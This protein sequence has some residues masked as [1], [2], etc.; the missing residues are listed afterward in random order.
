MEYHIVSTT[1]KAFGLAV[2]IPVEHDDIPLFVGTCHHVRSH[3]HPPQA[4]AFQVVA[5]VVVESGLVARITY[6][7]AIV[8][9]YEELRNTIAVHVAQRNVVDDVLRCGIFTIAVYHFCNGKLLVALV[10]T[11]H[12]GTLRLFNALHYSRHLILCGSIATSVVV[13]RGLQV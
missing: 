4:F 6:V 10:P 1:K 11:C 13:V 9:L 7:T 12:F 5:F 2:L 8:T 3:V